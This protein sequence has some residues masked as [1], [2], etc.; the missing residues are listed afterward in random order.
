M[1]IFNFIGSAGGAFADVVREQD[2]L[3]AKENA[4]VRSK[5][6]TSFIDRSQKKRD[7]KRKAN[8]EAVEMYKKLVTVGYSKQAA[9]ALVKQG[10]GE[11]FYENAMKLKFTKGIDLPSL[12]EITHPELGSS[13]S[14]FEGDKSTIQTI[15]ED[16]V[17][18]FTDPDTVPIPET[19]QIGERSL[20]RGPVTVDYG[21]TAKALGLKP[22][23]ADVEQ[24][25]EQTV[26]ARIDTDRLKNIMDNEGD[27]LKKAYEESKLKLIEFT[28]QKENGT[29]NPDDA[30]KIPKLENLVMKLG[31]ALSAYP[32]NRAP[33]VTN[34][35]RRYTE[36]PR[37][38]IESMLK[39]SKALVEQGGQ[40]LSNPAITKL[41]EKFKDAAEGKVVTLEEYN[42]SSMILSDVVGGFK[43]VKPRMDALDKNE[44]DRLESAGMDGQVIIVTETARSA[45]LRIK[46]EIDKTAGNIA[47]MV[48][49]PK[50]LKTP[51]ETAIKNK[52]TSQI[53]SGSTKT[54]A[55]NEFNTNR[56]AL[57]AA[58]SGKL[59]VGDF[60]LI[61][62]AFAIYTGLGILDPD[63]FSDN[64]YF[65]ATTKQ[66]LINMYK[67]KQVG[68]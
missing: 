46:N 7:S 36:K 13:N 55:P 50:R 53:I 16:S 3:K 26:A 52:I 66:E 31:K 27:S 35:D 34:V 10:A 61:N 59:R 14:T 20:T 18:P 62:G 38:I 28:I 49:S 56:E 25:T 60:V 6:I 44:I 22:E 9:S 57:E 29:L 30:D 41:S 23:S 47:A 33:T 64:F 37:T 45:K 58:N 63:I 65:T 21:Q 11:E 17:K 67:L 54:S 2:A 5:L 42:M 1:S 32:N 12:V 68:E 19:V 8:K 43:R 4:A 24:P 39:T 51:V 15:T 48:K 40:I